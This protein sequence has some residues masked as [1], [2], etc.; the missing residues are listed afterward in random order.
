MRDVPG[1]ASS[2][3]STATTTSASRWPTRSPPS[4]AG[5]RQVEC[6]HQRHRRARGQRG[7][8]GDRDGRARA[9]R[10]AAASRRASSHASCSRTSQLLSHVTGV[11]PQ[12][13]KAIVGRNA[14]AHE[15]GIHQHGVLQNGAHVRDHGPRSSRAVAVELVLGKHSGR[16]ALRSAA[17]GA[18]LRPRRRSELDQAFTR[19]SRTWPTAQGRLRRRP[20]RD[21]RARAPSRGRSWTSSTGRH[22]RRDPPTAT[23]V[24]SR[25]GRAR[26]GG[27]CGRQRPGGRG[28]EGGRRG[29]RLRAQLLEMHTRAVTAGKDA[30][31]EVTVRVVHDGIDVAR[32]GRRARTRSRRRASAY[33]LR[34]GRPRGGPR[35]RLRRR[36][37]A[38]ACRATALREDLGGAPRAGG[39]GR[40]A[41]DPL[42]RPAPGAR[43]HLAAGLRRAARAPG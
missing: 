36:A 33:R 34:R 13:N 25:G 30:V 41:G 35:G 4:Q 39:D 3:P 20:G 5:A 9:P 40:D 21:R 14:F 23:V 18:R 1:R 17:R 2:S 12:P 19:A 29:A 43:G 11:C 32:P 31:G 6:T 10:R 38:G 8:R 37:V 26:G 7:A 16:H 22:R 27:L 28:A 42:R 15:A 24:A